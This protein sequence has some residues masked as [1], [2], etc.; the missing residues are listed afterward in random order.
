MENRKEITYINKS[1]DGKKAYFT[2]NKETTNEKTFIVDMDKLRNFALYGD[3]YVIFTKI[4]K[5][6][7]GQ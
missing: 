3:T 1:K 7:G 6:T 2:I 4:E 5:K